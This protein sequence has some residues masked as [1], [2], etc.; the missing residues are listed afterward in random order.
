MSFSYRTLL[1]LSIT[2]GYYGGPCTDL[3]FVLPAD[4]AKLLEGGR[5]LARVREGVLHVLYDAD[6]GGSPV[7]SAAGRTLRI[8]LKQ[9]NPLFANITQG[10]SPSLAYYLNNETPGQLDTPLQMT[11]VGQLFP[12]PLA[13]VARPVSVGVSDSEGRTLRIETVT[14]DEDRPTVSFDFTGTAPGFLKVGEAYPDEVT[15]VTH[16]Y[17]DPELQQEGA[18]AVIELRLDESF[19]STPPAFTVAY[20][21]R[22]E[23]L[24]YYLVAGNHTPEDVELLDVQDA[25][26]TEDSR[27]Q[28]EFDRLGPDKFASDDLPA[29]LLGGSDAQVVLFKSKAPVLRQQKARRKL[30]LVR[31]STGDVLIE[32]LP[33]PGADRPHADLIIHVS[34]P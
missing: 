29:G 23:L 22:E 27:Q 13:D 30:Q 15:H 5:M 25:G 3:G 28:I 20:Q 32:H 31:T 11:P 9:L 6:A 1:T 8:G 33:Q 24:K 17:L 7:V 14:A 2:H 34:K 16:Y 19:Y 21:A 18:L 12:H 26:F 10:V 4:T